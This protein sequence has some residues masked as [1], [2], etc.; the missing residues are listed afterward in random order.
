[1]ALFKTHSSQSSLPEA[2]V[3]HKE[4]SGAPKLVT[5]SGQFTEDFTRRDGKT[6]SLSL[7]YFRRVH[8][9]NL[10]IFIDQWPATVPSLIG[11]SV[12]T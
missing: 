3:S 7:G 4:R 11:A 10:P 2:N 9:H 8:A 12:W 5:A 1:M 6:K